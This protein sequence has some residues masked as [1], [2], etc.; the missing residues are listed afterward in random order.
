M[1]AMTRYLAVLLAGLMLVSAQ[2]IEAATDWKEGQHYFRVQVQKRTSVPAGMVE[3]MEVFSYGC[4]ACD[5]FQPVVHKLAGGL[6]PNARMVYLPASFNPAEAWPMFQRAY[7][8]AQALGIAD[9]T[10]DAMYEAVWKTGELGIS[11]PTTHKLKRTLPSIEDAAR[12]Y[13]KRTGVAVDKFVATSKS[14]SVEMKMKEADDL[15]RA[16]QVDGTPTLIVNGKYR[17]NN[18]AMGSVEQMI[19]L[20]KFLVAQEGTPRSAA[21]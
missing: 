4:I 3:V 18:Q 8:T 17:V 5:R 20:V 19:E 12:W 10:H 14:F 16:Y 9:K 21:R 7:L 1:L 6:P 2:G 15:V 11:D 13:N